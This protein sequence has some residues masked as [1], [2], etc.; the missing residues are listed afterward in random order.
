MN[1]R[2]KK[3]ILILVI[4]IVVCFCGIYLFLLRY[5]FYNQYNIYAQRA[6]LDQLRKRYHQEFEL[7][8][9]EF[10]TKEVETGGASYVH[11]WTFIVQDE[12]GRQFNAYVRLYGLVEKGDGSFHS[13]DYSTYVDDTYGQLCIE[14]K[15]ESRFNLSQYRQEKGSRLDIPGWEDYLF[16]CTNDNID[17]IAALLTEIYFQEREFGDGGSLKCLVNNEAGEEL[18]SYYWWDITRALQKQDK[19]I[20]EQT[21]SAYILQE[22]Q[23]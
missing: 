3:M 23:G 11:M 4:G 19:E 17:E 20:T 2:K 13:A 6:V 1:G 21:V 18:F 16:I 8:T 5:F 9:T 12:Q 10:E 7:L 22:L 14:E 15:L